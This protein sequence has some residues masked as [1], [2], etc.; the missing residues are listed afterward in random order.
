KGAVCGSNMHQLTVAGTMWLEESKRKRAPVHLGWAPHVM[1]MMSGDPGPFECPSNTGP[2]IPAVFIKQERTGFTYPSL[3]IDSGYFRRQNGL[4]NGYY[5]AD[6][7]TEADTAGGDRDFDDAYV[8]TKPI[9][10]KKAE[11]YAQKTGTGRELSLLDWRTRTLQANFSTSNKFIV[12]LIRGGM[13]MNISAA[14]SGVKPWHIFFVDYND[15]TACTETGF[16]IRSRDNQFRGDRPR[17][18]EW[19]QPRHN[20]KAN[21]S[22]VD[23]SIKKMEEARLIPPADERAASIWHPQRQPGW[24]G[25]LGQ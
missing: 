24:T 7:E 1:R 3:S 16:Y 20:K 17:R 9:G 21:V 5:R 18:P 22:F 23:G 15:W 14:S 10:P 25:V 13:A 11:V 6:M 12:P 2:P 19:V 8:Y 4:Y